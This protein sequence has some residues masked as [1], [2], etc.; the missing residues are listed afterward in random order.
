M[1][2]AET[3]TESPADL[4][5]ALEKF[6]FNA[7]K[8]A[9]RSQEVLAEF[10][11]RTPPTQGDNA[12]VAASIDTAKT[13][14]QEMLR[15][16][17]E[18]PEAW[19]LA[20]H[21]LYQESLTLWANTVARMMGEDIPPAFPPAPK[22]RRFRDGAWEDLPLF[23]F[24]KQSY[25][26]VSAWLEDIEHRVP[27][28][29]KKKVRTVEFYTRQFLNAL[30]PSNF[31][32]TNPQ[33]LEETLKTGGDNLVKGLE[34]MLRDLRDNGRQMQ[35]SM[36]DRR[37]FALGKN[38]VLSKGKVIFRNRLLELLQYTPTT[39][40]VHKTPLLV[41]S[42]WINKYYI[43]DLKPEN[44]FVKFLTD[45]GHTVFITS[46]VNPGQE[47]STVNFEDYMKEGALAAMEAV[48]QATGEEKLNVIGYCL[49]GTLLSCTLAYLHALKKEKPIVSA[50]F[51][52]TLV[53]FSEPGD[54]GVF[55]TEEQV[56]ALEQQMA[57]TG[58]LDG[59]DMAF[60]F[61]MLR[62]NELIWSF[63]VNNYLMGREAMPFDLLYWNT[64]GTCLP[65]AMHLFY[66]RKMYI[67]NLLMKPGGIQLSG[68]PIDVR[69]VAT[70]AYFLSTREDHI[71]PWVSTY[72]TTQLFQGEKRFVLS[73]SGHVAGVVNPPG[74]KYGHWVDERLSK[75]YPK[76][77]EE[78]FKGAEYHPGSWWEDWHRWAVERGY[79][80][81]TIPAAARIPGT[82]KLK[83][84]ED[85]PGSY[86]KVRLE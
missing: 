64:D 35:V 31:L 57:E 17:A 43:L 80:G 78:W 86:V 25:L 33:A 74:G 39:E 28:L 23:D 21:D 76:Q 70:P 52:T 18:H 14:F 2:I 61:N 42:P 54:L 51:L 46:W 75:T 79:A 66:L 68:V 48:S 60:I 26:L 4:T 41:I 32:L 1:H 16:W 67:H 49:G 56:V 6:S 45:Q 58:V 38:I 3:V 72:T 19:C 84:L 73:A 12:V 7:A 15:H 27:G 13:A 37:A 50:T 10:L 11:Q 29:D 44:S 20:L 81:A 65:A 55:I 9:E 82:G 36:T 71:A 47:L 62:S 22:D 24:F 8:I 63:V 5:D 34:N 83:A 85:A 40:Q 69:R 59:R 53:D 30:S 77:P